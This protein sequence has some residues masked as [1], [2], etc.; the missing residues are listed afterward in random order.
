MIY[1]QKRF[2]M[3]YNNFL[4]IGVYFII[5][6]K[7]VTAFS[8]GELNTRKGLIKIHEEIW[9]RQ[10]SDGVEVDKLTDVKV[11]HDVLAQDRQWQ[12]V[13]ANFKPRRRCRKCM[14]TLVDILSTCTR[15]IFLSYNTT[16][17]TTVNTTSDC[18]LANFLST[19]SSSNNILR[20]GIH[21]LQNFKKKKKKEKLIIKKTKLLQTL[22]QNSILSTYIYIY[23]I[24][25]FRLEEQSKKFTYRPFTRSFTRFRIPA[26]EKL[27]AVGRC[28]QVP[29]PISAPRTPL[30]RVLQGVMDHPW[31]PANSLSYDKR[32]IALVSTKE[33]PP[34]RSATPTPS[35]PLCRGALL[36]IIVYQQGRPCAVDS[37]TWR[38]P[39]Y[40]PPFSTPPLPSP[41]AVSSLVAMNDEYRVSSNRVTTLTRWSIGWELGA[42]GKRTP[43]WKNIRG[44]MASF[45]Y[46][47]YRVT[48][49]VP[50]DI[51]IK[52]DRLSFSKIFFLSLSLCLSMF[53]F[54]RVFKRNEWRDY[55]LSVLSLL[56]NSFVFEKR[57]RRTKCKCAWTK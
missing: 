44:A 49:A 37:I 21:N 14:D 45:I 8:W 30:T 35:S 1:I 6:C 19:I 10:V 24:L 36:R 53:I 22:K 39:V 47:G 31:R 54:I 26:R 51:R 11:W 2:E 32:L 12:S 40:R 48:D 13:H 7:N 27:D 55:F 34:T 46:M 57:F 28:K 38:I 4:I 16:V 50:S 43:R 23:I 52:D 33:P 41:C 25:Y 18:T 56:F 15:S 42:R 9:E 5:R 17:H 3:R 29:K 20:E